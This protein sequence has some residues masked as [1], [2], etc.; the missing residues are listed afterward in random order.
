MS[1]AALIAFVGLV[2]GVTVPLRGHALG[3]SR[4]GRRHRHK[5][6]PSH[7]RQSRRRACLD[8]GIALTEVATRLRSGAS[9]EAAWALTLEHSGVTALAQRIKPDAGVL[10]A[11]GVPSALRTLWEAG[12]IRRLR[13]GVAPV[14]VEALPAAF[15]VCRM[16]HATGAPMAEILDSCAAGIAEAGE[17][18]SAREVAMAGPKSSAHMLAVLPLVG[19]ALGLVMGADPLGFLLDT[20]WGHVALAAGIGFE[21]AGILAVRRLIHQAVQEA[22]EQ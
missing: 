8:I 6:I 17:A 15:A 3:E 19:I 16:G 14:A 9:M 1:I 20:F 18:R 7:A 13:L 21:V 4:A 22:E 10:D 11:A 5:R 12:K 2:A